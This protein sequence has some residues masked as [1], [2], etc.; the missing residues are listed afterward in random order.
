M[1]A[2]APLPI[3]RAMYAGTTA[4]A[5]A[6]VGAASH[7]IILEIMALIKSSAAVCFAPNLLFHVIAVFARGS[8]KSCRGAQT[9]VA[10]AGGAGAR[11]DTDLRRA[12]FERLF[13]SLAAVAYLHKQR[14][15]K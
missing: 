12:S 7:V 6:A 9:H 14:A 15:T 10:P 11:A 1:G 3:T 2:L 5:R 8:T 4:A 13:S